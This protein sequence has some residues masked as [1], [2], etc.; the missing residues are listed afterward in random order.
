MSTVFEGGI[1]AI[2]IGTDNSVI[3]QGTI[4]DVSVSSD[5]IGLDFTE[6]MFRSSLSGSIVL[7]NAS[8]WDLELGGIQGTEWLTLVFDSEEYDINGEAKPYQIE[9]RFKIYKV[10]QSISETNE[11]T[12]YSLYFTTY[13]FLIDSVKFERHLNNNHIGPI[14][15][16]SS[17]QTGGSLVD[18]DYGLVN[19][20]FDSAG[21]EYDIN[22][23]GN[24]N[25]PVLDIEETNNWINF[26]PS[27]LDNR[28]TPDTLDES[29]LYNRRT[30]QTRGNDTQKDARPKKVFEL[31]SELAENSVSKENPNAANYFIWNDLVGWHFR[32]VDSFLR[33]REGEVDRIYSY[34]PVTPNTPPS[35][36]IN[37]IINLNVIKQVNFLDLLNKQALS[38]KVIYYEMNPDNEFS[39]YYLTL[40]SALTGL[41]KVLGP[42]GID[43]SIGNTVVENEAVIE[44]ELSYDYLLDYDK[45]SKVEDYPLIQGFENQYTDYTLP[46]FLEVPP[47]YLADG[48]GKSSW[49]GS[50]SYDLN[51]EYYNFYQNM[52]RT[53]DSFAVTNPHE[54]FKTKFLRQTELSGFNF[55][56][57]HDEIKKPIINAL[58]EYYNVCLQRLF[59]EHNLVITS[60]INTLESGEGTIGRGPNKQYCEWCVSREDALASALSNLP[61]D[62][63]DLIRDNSHLMR[64]YNP[65]TQDWTLSNF[66]QL[67]FENTLISYSTRTDLELGE[68]N[69]GEFSG[70]TVCTRKARDGRSDTLGGGWD[71]RGDS[72]EERAQAIADHILSLPIFESDRVLKIDSSVSGVDYPKCFSQEP[73]LKY[74]GDPVDCVTIKEK[75]EAIP[76]ECGLIRR[77][78]GD[79]Y[80]SP[81]IRGE[82]GDP[83]NIRNLGF[84]NGYWINPRFG[85]PNL[86][87]FLK[88]WGTY[89][90]DQFGGD[91]SDLDG[92]YNWSQFFESNIFLKDFIK[93]S[94]N[95][96]PYR[97]GPNL[98]GGSYYWGSYFQSTAPGWYGW[99][100]YGWGWGLNYTSA[101]YGISDGWYHPY[102]T[103]TGRGGRGI[104]DQ[105]SIIKSEFG[106]DKRD[107]FD[108]DGNLAAGSWREGT[109]SVSIEY[110]TNRFYDLAKTCAIPKLCGGNDTASEVIDA[111]YISLYRTTLQDPG[112]WQVT[113]VETS[114]LAIRWP[115]RYHPGEP[116]HYGNISTIP[117]NIDSYM[118]N[119]L[120]DTYLS[121]LE[122][123]GLASRGGVID[124]SRGFVSSATTASIQGG[125]KEQGNYTTYY[126]NRNLGLYNNSKPIYSKKDLQNFQDCGGTCVG[127]TNTP[128]S[129]SSKAIEYAKYCSYGWNRYWSTP[130]EQILYRKAQVNLIQS[131]EIEIQIPNDMNLKIG[132]L[133]RIDMPKSS[134]MGSPGETE[135]ESLINPISGK[136]LVTGIRRSF[137]NT[138]QSMKVRLNRDSLPYDP[139][140]Q[141]L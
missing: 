4:V 111:P 8:G 132:N 58:K 84:W 6:D 122:Q 25:I 57:V 138:T 110:K 103:S 13:Q 28:D 118:G 18:Q 34:S 134:S 62:L 27:Y 12:L 74:N 32:S 40:P 19:K 33:G 104:P 101:W 139:N 10:S 98:Y 9:Q 15:T 56:I 29:Y 47:A 140:S 107:I 123:F 64:T 77:Y 81:A 31:L 61:Q 37:T 117:F 2:K 100:G 11:V 23:T 124:D 14:A 70:M 16:N 41:Q 17:D 73:P 126:P 83:V 3:G 128:V 94:D 113:N 69:G 66:D 119:P 49:F 102:A 131:Q 80:V 68:G 71:T 86:R 46:S 42:A 99:W 121:F 112:G 30:S 26:I 130:K 91:S 115:A 39:Q 89:D 22:V 136:Y 135:R 55:R 105:F 48:I 65:E 76:S 45:W 114:S 38:S 82:N 125:L 7:S 120:D 133:V 141:S 93:E 67:R 88:F 95:S 72:V 59:Y 53:S 129:D 87:N 96:V 108:E 35:G 90:S 137:G 79:E 85:L 20:I 75:F 106:D 60:G 21:F 36:E 97:S 44:G 63:I 52:H 43:N 116:Y 54:Y 24:S 5:L 109:T 50:S 127:D 51:N 1:S 78:L 92:G